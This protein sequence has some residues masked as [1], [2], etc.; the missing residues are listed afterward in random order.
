MDTFDSAKR[1]M[2][3]LYLQRGDNETLINKKV[4][5]IS[6]VPLDQPYLKQLRPLEDST[7]LRDPDYNVFTN[8]DH[9]KLLPV[10]FSWWYENEFELSSKFFPFIDWQFGWSAPVDKPLQCTAEFELDDW[11]STYFKVEGDGSQIWYGITPPSSYP[12]VAGQA[13]YSSFVTTQERIDDESVLEHHT[14]PAWKTSIEWTSG[15]SQYK[16]TNACLVG[17]VTKKY[18]T[19]SS[20]CGDNTDGYTMTGSMFYDSHCAFPAGNFVDVEPDGSSFEVMGRRVHE[21][22]TVG[23]GD[24]PS[25]DYNTNYTDGVTKT[26]SLSDMNYFVV[27]GVRMKKVGGYWRYD[28]YGGGFGYGTYHTVMAADITTMT[29]TQEGFYVYWDNTR[30][31]LFAIRYNY[32]TTPATPVP[33]NLPTINAYTAMPYY[34]IDYWVNPDDYPQRRS[35]RL[36]YKTNNFQVA[37]VQNNG[38]MT[39]VLWIRTSKSTDKKEKW[40]ARH[41][42]SALRMVE[43]SVE[44]VLDFLNWHD[45]Y[46]RVDEGYYEGTYQKS[47]ES[48]EI[49]HKSRWYTPM[50]AINL[51]VVAMARSPF[52]W[53]KTQKFN[54]KVS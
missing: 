18:D 15:G 7:V 30:R 41:A 12:E 39:D 3:D 9:N 50:D 38:P 20:P 53:K 6:N 44:N 16:I 31:W 8:I 52:Y 5:D 37:Y 49:K 45:V 14:R 2:R 47:S 17:Y 51:R 28:P 23:A 11:D 46:T 27:Y 34:Q 4:N 36:G 26:F 32:S 42:Y 1:K 24:P 19:S 54:T 10:N 43:A 13:S 48:H 35:E 25:C 29:V 22:W 21:W 40:L 33:L